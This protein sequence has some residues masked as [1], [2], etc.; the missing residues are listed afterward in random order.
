MSDS[1]IDDYAAEPDEDIDELQF[2][3]S[4]MIARATL[5]EDI[6]NAQTIQNARAILKKLYYLFELR[7]A[8]RFA[9]CEAERAIASSLTD[10]ENFDRYNAAVSLHDAAI[11]FKAKVTD[12]FHSFAT[13]TL[14]YQE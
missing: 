13:S 12:F 14:E 2:L 3:K 8:V 10:P 7:C 6:N 9:F 4:Y 5:Y 11:R 1:S